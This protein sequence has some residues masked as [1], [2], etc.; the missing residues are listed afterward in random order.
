MV[1]Q[2]VQGSSQVFHHCAECS[3]L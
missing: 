3:V 1:F 2:A